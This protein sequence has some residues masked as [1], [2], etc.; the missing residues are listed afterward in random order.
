MARGGDIILSTDQQVE[1]VL[2]AFNDNLSG[3]VRSV[4][5]LKLKGGIVCDKLGFPRRWGPGKH[6]IEYDPRFR[7]QNALHQVWVSRS[8]TFQRYTEREDDA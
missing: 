7:P 4:K 2:M 6:V 8:I 5:P 1:A 3:M